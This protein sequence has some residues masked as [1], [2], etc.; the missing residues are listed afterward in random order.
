MTDGNCHTA[1]VSPASATTVS[2]GAESL[3]TAL[4]RMLCLFVP[5]LCDPLQN[6]NAQFSVNS[7][8]C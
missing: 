1:E 6:E 2:T 7:Y 8:E 3:Q 5:V 4:M